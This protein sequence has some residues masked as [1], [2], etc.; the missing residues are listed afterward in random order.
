MKKILKIIRLIK[1][2]NH[3]LRNEQGLMHLDK[4]DMDLDKIEDL[5]N[6]SNGGL[7]L[8]PCIIKIKH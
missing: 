4:T 2:K 1:Q 8:G 7:F 5:Y 6:M 3:L